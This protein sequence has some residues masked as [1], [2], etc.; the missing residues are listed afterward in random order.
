MHINHII[1]AKST[2]LGWIGDLTAGAAGLYSAITT[3]LA[4]SSHGAISNLPSEILEFADDY[5]V[6]VSLIAGIYSIVF[7][8]VK[9]F[10][11]IAAWLRK[12]SDEKRLLAIGRGEP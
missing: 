3:Y 9:T 5:Q 4:I 1:V 8:G 2:I 10:I 11:G 6:L 12:R 7:L